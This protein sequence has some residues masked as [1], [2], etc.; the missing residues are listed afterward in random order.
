MYVTPELIATS[1]SMMTNASNS[2]FRGAKIRRTTA[3]G[4]NTASDVQYAVTYGWC[5]SRHP[6]KMT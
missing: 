1:V 3:S 6:I 4:S 5:G 2:P